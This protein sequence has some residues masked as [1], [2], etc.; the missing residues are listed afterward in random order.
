MEFGGAGDRREARGLIVGKGVLGCCSAVA[1][2]LCPTAEAELGR[3]LMAAARG[4]TAALVDAM[5]IHGE[6]E[7]EEE[8]GMEKTRRGMMG[9]DECETVDEEKASLS[10]V[11][12]FS[13]R[14]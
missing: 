10:N 14:D 8:R 4:R 2:L 5:V 7:G 6:K 3:K 13:L 9:G 12:P 11:T 1:K